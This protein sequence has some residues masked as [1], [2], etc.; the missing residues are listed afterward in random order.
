MAGPRAT[1]GD[2]EAV[3]QA[4]GSGGFAILQ[5]SKI[6]EGAPSQGL[7]DSRVAIRPFSA[8][9]GRHFCQLDWHVILVAD[10]EPVDAT[11]S[12]QDAQAA[13]DAL[14]IT[15][16][17]D[18]APLPLTRTAVKQFLDPERF[19]LEDAVFA[20]WGHI[21]SPTD[22]AVGRHTLS[23]QFGSEPLPEIE[24]FIDAEG[25]GACT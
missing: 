13:V 24:F 23:G 7:S 17:L 1:K 12:R 10:I 15:L 2:A 19:G 21:I 6:A 14:A 16:T 8:W 25:S 9:D 20:Q 3:L 18:G 5:H 22:L 4:G 11:S